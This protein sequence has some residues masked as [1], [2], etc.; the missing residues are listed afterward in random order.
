MSWASFEM[1]VSSTERWFL[2]A[3]EYCV[4]K[5]WL[6]NSWTE[7]AEENYKQP[8][9]PSGQTFA[10]VWSY[11]MCWKLDPVGFLK[12]S[13]PVW[14]SSFVTREIEWAHRIHSYSAV[15]TEILF[16]VNL[17]VTGLCTQV[18]EVHWDSF[19]IIHPLQL[20]K[21]AFH[22]S[23][24]EIERKG[25]SKFPSVSSNTESEPELTEYIPAVSR[26]GM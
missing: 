19:L 25:N 12:R 1:R 23:E 24:E 17:G 2:F 20:R 16:S 21:V 6:Y 11:W 26:R 13:V 7:G 22:Y 4:P 9:P 3:Y 14:F 18:M 10:A 15:S 8:C 5:N